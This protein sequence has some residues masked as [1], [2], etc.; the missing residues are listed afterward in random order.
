[1]PVSH[2]VKITV[3]KKESYEDLQKEYLNN[4]EAGP[5]PM[6]ETGQEFIV[7]GGGFARMMDGKFC[8]EAWEAISK[9]IYAGLQGGSFMRGWM[10]EENVMIA[11]CNDGT[12]PVVFKLERIDE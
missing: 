3:I 12:R 6:F 9:Y 1:M 8:S 11:C 7:D 2:K 5:C 4:T 10:R